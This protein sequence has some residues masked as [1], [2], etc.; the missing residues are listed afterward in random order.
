MN[1]ENRARSERRAKLI[2]W[3]I[4]AAT[5]TILV[6]V[7]ASGGLWSARAERSPNLRT[8]GIAA[9]P[10]SKSASIVIVGDDATQLHDELKYFGDRFSEEQKRL[11][12]QPVAAHVQAF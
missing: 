3:E 9:A 2:W 8:S 11:H 7:A 1:L 10:E 4:V 5:I 6:I 12:Q